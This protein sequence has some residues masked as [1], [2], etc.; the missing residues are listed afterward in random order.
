[1]TDWDTIA[2]LVISF[3]TLAIVINQIAIEWGDFKEYFQKKRRK[4]E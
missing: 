4:G 3:V 2:I 1:M